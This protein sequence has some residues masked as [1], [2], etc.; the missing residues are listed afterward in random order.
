VS[1]GAV[2]RR[3]LHQRWVAGAADVHRDATIHHGAGASAEA[4]SDQP[5]GRGFVYRLAVLPGDRGEEVALVRQQ[6]R[7]A[8]QQ[9]GWVT[10]TVAEAAAAALT[11]RPTDAGCGGNG[12][13]G[14]SSTVY[15]D[16][17]WAAGASAATARRLRADAP[18]PA[19][20]GPPP[21]SSAGS[22]FWYSTASLQVLR[23]Q[24]Q[25]ENLTIVDC[26]G[27]DH[28]MTIRWGQWLCRPGARGLEG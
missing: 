1:S 7:E 26:A 20:D 17:V 21:P 18:P 8:E 22:A 14:S 3:A 28:A 27:Q 2:S 24:L 19:P 10:D 16:Q 13:G 12:G 6:E 11:A 25:Q 15:D 23:S 4:A 9:Q 5:A